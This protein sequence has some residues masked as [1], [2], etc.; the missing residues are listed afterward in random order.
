LKSSAKI[1]MGLIKCKLC[2]RFLIRSV[3]EFMGHL[4]YD[5]REEFIERCEQV[6]FEDATDRV[7]EL[8]G[9]LTERERKALRFGVLPSRLFVLATKA[10]AVALIERAE[11]VY[12]E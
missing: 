10:E 12:G 3:D 11:E 4:L 2:G 5:H 1:E 8:W 7:N 9:K 6:F